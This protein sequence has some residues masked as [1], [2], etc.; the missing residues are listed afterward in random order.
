[1]ITQERLKELLHYDPLTGVFTWL[2]ATSNRVRV[3]ATAGTPSKKSCKTYLVFTV[4]GIKQTSHRWA[5]LYMRGFIPPMVDHKDRNGLNNIWSNLR[6][7]NPK[8]NQSN[9][10]VY[11]TARH[12]INGVRLVR[13]RYEVTLN[14]NWLGVAKDFFEA[15]CL[16]KSAENML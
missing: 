10:S 11:K 4:D 2:K 16:R 15:C 3:G 6:E 12:G 7:S 1:M 8:H 5:F 13:G 14:R 9:L